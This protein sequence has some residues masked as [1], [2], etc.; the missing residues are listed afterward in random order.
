[1]M[2]DR[3]ILCPITYGYRVN[4]PESSEQVNNTYHL[5]FLQA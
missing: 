5:E 4:L 2:I 1:M 3:G